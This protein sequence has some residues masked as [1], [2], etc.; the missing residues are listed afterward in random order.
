VED[1]EGEMNKREKIREIITRDGVTLFN[2]I[3]G[4]VMN[5]DHYAL[6]ERGLPE[7]FIHIEDMTDVD[8]VLLVQELIGRLR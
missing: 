6:V 5:A 3:T 7:G 4:E 2:K 1:E 8:W